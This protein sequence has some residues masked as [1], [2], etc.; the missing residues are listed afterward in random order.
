MKPIL[1][2]GAALMIGA[3]IYGFVDYENT[4]HKKEFTTMYSN[5]K[6]NT[7][8]QKETVA[9]DVKITTDK[10]LAE[11]SSVVRKE[12][13]KTDKPAVNTAETKTVKKAAKRKKIRLSEFS[14]API[15]E[16]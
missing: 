7:A 13:S 4:K 3:S 14:R 2:A 6:D 8:V 1:Y 9:T 10:K 15:R 12:E 5:E 16:R 11:N